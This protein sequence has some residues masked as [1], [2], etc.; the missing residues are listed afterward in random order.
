[1]AQWLTLWVAAASLL[2]GQAALENT[3]KPMSV[4]FECAA[5]ELQTAE[6][7]CSEQEPCR[8]F[9]ELSGVEAAGNRIFLTGNIHT[10]NTT[11]QSVLLATD[12]S[13]K[14]WTEPVPRMRFTALDQIQFVDFET[15]WISGANTQSTPRDPF[16]LLTTDGGKT[17]H[18]RPI[19][20]ESRSGVIEKFWFESKSS[21][22]LLIDDRFENRHELYET[23]TGGE[24]WSLRHTSTN[25]IRF[26]A[27]KGTA[28]NAWRLR[29]DAQTHAF[30]VER[31]QGEHWQKVASFLVEIA[32]CVL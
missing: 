5:D 16:L 27:I 11:L 25:S 24:S 10:G 7:N 32:K 29:A 30:A 12:D 14:T 6:S 19:Y 17:W 9:L 13:G 1:V 26:P 21:G 20:D 22:T 15:G 23:M 28:I 3:G 2:A 18:Q 8:I 31:S 4:P